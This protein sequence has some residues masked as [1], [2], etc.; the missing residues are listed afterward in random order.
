[1]TITDLIERLEKATGPS[2]ELE[3][4]IRHELLCPPDAYVAQSPINGA[5]CIYRGENNGRPN[6]YERAY[7]VPFEVWRGEYTASIDAVLGLLSH[8][9][10]GWA[11]S[12]CSCCFTD[13]AQIWP[14]FNSKEN[15]ER[16]RREF[17][18]LL[19]PN[20]EWHQPEMEWIEFTD[21]A[22]SPPGR[23]AIALCI[24]LLTAMERINEL[25]AKAD[26]K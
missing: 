21:V 13:D 8:V 9:L 24:S 7:E 16:L 18:E 25:K 4:R 17:P 26:G 20:R 5:W 12:A 22:L 10:P 15:G 2:R 1:M 23:P 19:V 11:W 14:D 3:A 6:L